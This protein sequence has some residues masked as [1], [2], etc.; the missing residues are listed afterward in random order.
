LSATT[1]TLE[2][3]SEEFLS[4]VLSDLEV[5]REQSASLLESARRETEAAV[6]K[7]LET[8]AKQAASAKRQML[9]SAE[10]E[11]RNLQLKALEDA[12][13][14]VFAEGV[15]RLP[16]LAPP[17]REEALDR[18]IREGV[19]VIGEKATVSCNA[20]DRKAVASVVRALNKDGA[21]LKLEQESIQT[22]GGVTLQSH[23]GT[24]RFEN[25]FEARLERMKQVLRKEI[26]TTLSGTGAA[27]NPV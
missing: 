20:A 9:D 25:T 23:D 19:Q 5:G 15:K 7:M 18:L 13:N 27:R 2:K 10:L 11:A 6:T 4:E 1:N 21:K 16:D 12:V 3:V 22:I 14:E 26:A 17:Q 8:G 24:V